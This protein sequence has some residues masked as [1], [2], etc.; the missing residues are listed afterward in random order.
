MVAVM[1]KYNPF[2][3]KAGMTRVIF[4]T[5]G[6]E[7]LKISQCLEEL[8]FNPKLYGSQ[9]YVLNRLGTLTHKHFELMKETFARNHHPRLSKEIVPARR[10]LAFGTKEAYVKGI[11]EA[12]ILKIAKLIKVVGMLLQVKAYL[13]WRKDGNTA[14]PRKRLQ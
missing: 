12:D 8:G 6:K 2:A 11:Q 14:S 3:E 10:K 13:F 9:A 1:A 5:P 7:A 4:Q